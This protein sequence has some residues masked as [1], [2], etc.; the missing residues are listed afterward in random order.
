MTRDL[1]LPRPRLYGT[2]AQ[3]RRERRRAA[4]TDSQLIS[5]GEFIQIHDDETIDVMRGEGILVDNAI[6]VALR[7][8]V[9]DPDA[10]D[11]LLSAPTTMMKE[12]T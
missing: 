9:T 3:T 6:A 11:D 2:T 8:S 12:G 1:R 5:V 10:F 7:L 4:V